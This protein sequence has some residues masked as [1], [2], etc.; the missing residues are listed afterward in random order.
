MKNIVMIYCDE[1]RCDA[2]SCYGNPYGIK[3]E[4]IDELAAHGVMF[5]EC[6]C[7]SPVC[8]PSRYSTLTS[9]PPTQ[10]GVYHNEAAMPSFKLDHESITFPQVL[11]DGGYCTASFGKTHIPAVQ[12]PIFDVNDEMGGEMNLGINIKEEASQIMKLPGQFQSVLAAD[13]PADKKFGR[14][15]LLITVS[16]GCLT[17]VSLSLSVS[18]ICS[19]I[20][21]LWCLKSMWND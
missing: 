19:R 4:N 3:T 10:T 5:D 15:R 7:A 13:Y 1:L 17:S 8:V 20:H 11:K 14:S 12:T 21:P 16:S 9:L 18:V 6:Y 2:L